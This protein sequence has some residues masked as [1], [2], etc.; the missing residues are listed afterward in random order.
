MR[1]IIGRQGMVYINPYFKRFPDAVLVHCALSDTGSA[2]IA[3]GRFGP[4]KSVYNYTVISC[5]ATEPPTIFSS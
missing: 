2:L 3:K 5:A 1:E 4:T